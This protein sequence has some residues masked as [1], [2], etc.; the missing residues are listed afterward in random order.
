MDYRGIVGA[1]AVAA[2]LASGPA[3]AQTGSASAP[4]FPEEELPKRER[5]ADAEQGSL[6][7]NMATSQQQN[8]DRA[9]R[10][11]ERGDEGPGRTIARSDR[12]H[13]RPLAEHGPGHGER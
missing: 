10:G 4:P 13:E 1:L 3:W 8:Q 2:I 12:D 7:L 9:A 5:G 6:M 11:R